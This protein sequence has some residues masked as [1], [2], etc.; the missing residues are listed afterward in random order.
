MDLDEAA[1]NPGFLSPDAQPILQPAYPTIKSI[2]RLFFVFIFYSIIAGIVTV[3][4]IDLLNARK[5]GAQLTRSFLSLLMYITSLLAVIWYAARKSR[6]QSNA[7]FNAGFNKI[8]IWLVP[9]VILSALGL[10]VGLERVSYLLPMPASVQKFFENLIR[11]D[12][13]S[14]TMLVIAAP[15]LEELLCR[16]IVLNGLLKNYP[17]YKAIII[18]AVFFSALHLNPWQAIPAFFGGCFIGWVFYRTNSIIPGMIIHASING[19]FAIFS[20]LPSGHQNFLSI[21]GTPYYIFL[22]LIAVIVFVAGCAVIYKKTYPTSQQL[23]LGS[24]K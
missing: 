2:V 17:P 7:P 16:G 4:L 13:F 20:F 3:L 23:M 24:A 15:V 11:K 1:D 8:P 14:I 12:I 18:S 6:K 22:C 19:T 21:F 9:V 10:V 5:P